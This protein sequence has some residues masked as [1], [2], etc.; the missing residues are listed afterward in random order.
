M[1]SVGSLHILAISRTEVVPDERGPLRTFEM[2]QSSEIEMLREGCAFEGADLKP[3]S[4]MEHQPRGGTD[5]RPY[6][7]SVRLTPKPK[8]AQSGYI[9]L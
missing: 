1:K 3:V 7:R 5:R 6:R 8:L 2:H 4:G 9:R